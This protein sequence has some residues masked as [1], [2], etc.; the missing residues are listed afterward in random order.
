V[1]RD[2]KSDSGDTPDTSAEESPTTDDTVPNEGESA[3][4]ES[5]DGG[6]ADLTRALEERTADLQRVTAEY[7]NYRKRVERDKAAAAEHVTATVVAGLLPVLDDIDRARD[8][9]DLVGPFGT[10]AESLQASLTKLGLQVFGE[11]GD[12]FDPMVHEAVAHMHSDEVSETSC[13]DVLRR[14]YRIGERLLRPAMVAVAEPTE[15][16]IS[17]VVKVDA[18]AEPI[19]DA[20]AAET[21]AVPDREAEEIKEIAEDLEAENAEPNLAADVPPDEEA[22]KAEIV[23]DAVET[24]A[25]TDVEAGENSPDFHEERPATEKPPSE[26]E[27]DNTKTI[28]NE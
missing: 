21:E 9:G 12:P 3:V 2:S 22:L 7:H 19:E 25:T 20:Q 14:G 18:D 24:A 6:D 16:Q 1:T 5:A 11:K 4:D 26:T 17:E 10:V 28:E 27:P 23:A 15:A 13:I 8:H